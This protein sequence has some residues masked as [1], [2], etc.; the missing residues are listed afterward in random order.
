M[1]TTAA[2]H[3]SEIN[4]T[5]SGLLTAIQSDNY[6]EYTTPNGAKY[7]RSEFSKLLDTLYKVRDRLSRQVSAGSTGRVRVAKLGYARRTDR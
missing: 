2:E 5:I 7:R 3:L 6:E 1:A 4:A